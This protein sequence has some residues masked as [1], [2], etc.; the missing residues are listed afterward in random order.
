M[1]I[2]LSRFA[3]ILAEAG[4]HVKDG[5][6]RPCIYPWRYPFINDKQL[7][8]PFNL[9]SCRMTGKEAVLSRLTSVKRPLPVYLTGNDTLV[10]LTPGEKI[11]IT[12]TDA[13]YY[14]D[15]VTAD[16]TTGRIMLQQSPPDEWGW[17]IEGVP[18]Q[19]YFANE[20][21]YAG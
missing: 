20:L 16:G 11:I 14:A 10:E 5:R 18:A 13:Y 9:R 17:Y 6:G 4:R 3:C 7:C 1:R 2:R 8:T 21:P 15:F 19:K 12:G